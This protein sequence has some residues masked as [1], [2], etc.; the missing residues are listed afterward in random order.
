MFQ[1]PYTALL[2]LASVFAAT[3][4]A[5]KGT[6]G[7][8]AGTEADKQAVIQTLRDWSDGYVMHDLARLDRV[9]AEDWTYS[10][11]PSGAVVTRPDADR[12]FQTDTTRYLPW[13]YADLNVRFYGS[14]AVV[15]GRETISS[16]SAGKRETASY[17]FTA[18]FVKQEKQWRC[19]A[20]HSSAI[21]PGK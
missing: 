14:T 12:F 10:G 1:P 15:T 20:S 18:I 21:E 8:S 19:V 3:G 16:E 13:E 4:C 6:S 2:L 9:R 7:P 5:S 11:D 17:R